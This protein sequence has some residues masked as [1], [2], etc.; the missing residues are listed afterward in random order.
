MSAND[1]PVWARRLPRAPRVALLLAGGFHADHRPDAAVLDRLGSNMADVSALAEALRGPSLPEGDLAGTS[2][3]GDE[4]RAPLIVRVRGRLHRYDNIHQIGGHELAWRSH[5]HAWHALSCDLTTDDVIR[6]KAVALDL[7]PQPRLESSPLDDVVNRPSPRL[8]DG[9]AESL[10]LLGSS[11]DRVDPLALV[12]EGQARSASAWADAIVQALLEGEIERWATLAPWLPLLAEAGP[13]PFLTALLGQLIHDARGLW[14]HPSLRSGPGREPLLFALQILGWDSSLMPQVARCLLHL[15]AVDT[16]HNRALHPNPLSCLAHLLGFARP[17]TN[18]SPEQRLAILSEL[19]H[20]PEHRDAVRALLLHLWSEGP[21]RMHSSAARPRF[22]Q[23]HIP[24]DAP[25][26]PGESAYGQVQTY[27]ELLLM[28]AGHEA[29][30]W[31]DVVR[32]THVPDSL[33]CNVLER[34]L[35]LQGQMADPY[36]HICSALRSVKDWLARHGEPATRRPAFQR[37]SLLTDDAYVRWTPE[38]PVVRHAFLF[39]ERPTLADGIADYSTLGQ[40]VHVRQLAALQDFWQRE[41]RWE[42]LARLQALPAPP[43]EPDRKLVPVWLALALSETPFADPLE[44]RLRQGRSFAPFETLAP[45]FLALR[46][47]RRDLQET[48]ALLRHLLGSGREQDAQNLLREVTRIGG[49]EVQI[50]HLLDAPPLAPLRRTYWRDA[51]NVWMGERPPAEQERATECL[52]EAGNLTE[53]LWIAT[54]EKALSGPVLLRVFEALADAWGNSKAVDTWQDRG[55]QRHDVLAELVKHLAAARDVD[56]MRAVRAELLLFD[57]LSR[58]YLYEPVFLARAISASPAWLAE[59]L[60]DPVVDQNAD[61]TAESLAGHIFGILHQWHGYPGD[62][63]LRSEQAQ[64]LENWCLECLRLLPEKRDLALWI[65]G[66]LLVRPEPDTNDGLWPCRTAR[67][68]LDELLRDDRDRLRLL[69]S[70]VQA[71]RSARGVTSRAIG[72]GGEQERERAAQ[73]RQG[74]ER[75]PARLKWTRSLLEQLAADY[76]SDA[77]HHDEDAA[78]DRWKYTMATPSTTSKSEEHEQKSSPQPVSVFPLSRVKLESF[79]ALRD[80]DLRDLDPHLNVFVG[81]N[82]SGKTTVLDAIAAGLAAVQDE[83]F[84]SR[85]V[86]Q[87]VDPR[88]DRTWTWAAEGKATQADFLRLQY[89]GQPDPSQLEP[90]QGERVRPVEAL[91][92]NVY[93]SAAGGRGTRD[94]EREESALRSPLRPVRRALQRREAGPPPVPIFAYYDTKRAIPAEVM[95]QDATPLEDL[96]DGDWQLQRA[97]AYDGALDASASYKLLVS[98]LRSMQGAENEL[99]KERADFSA[100]LPELEAV[101]RAVEKTVRIN[102]SGGMRCWNP[103]TKSRQA[104]LLVDFDR[105]DGQPIETIE[106]AQ[107]SDGFRTHLALVMDL[108]RRMVHAN[109]PPGGDLNADG[110]G[111]NS[112]A[113]VLIDEVDLHLH[114]GWQRNVLDDLCAAFPNAQ[115]IVTTHS[116]QVLATVAR[117]HVRLLVNFQVVTDLFTEGR[118]TNGLLEEIFGISPRPRFI[119]QALEKLFELLDDEKFVEASEI[120]TSLEEKLGTNDEA[121]VRARWLLDLEQTA[122]GQ[123]AQPGEG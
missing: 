98:W 32:A 20:E 90:K 78:E 106:L 121:I 101:R 47:A 71:R 21:V 110:W 100:R 42:L 50:W 68:F 122:R 61:S 10:A 120:L 107:L 65:I 57:E 85:I 40:R 13:R 29:R 44:A 51:K 1:L 27:A 111:T 87:L 86:D 74:I 30:H 34:L 54:N 25:P 16:E 35:A 3:L 80:L 14:K 76:E 88:I 11:D 115:F 46:L 118:D 53:A 112:R 105:G 37:R 89:W 81:R 24:V 82:A 114:P 119:R 69:Q 8:M 77:R 26:P 33:A 52:L 23:L 109:P 31:A 75:I 64:T 108:A 79:R 5:R 9:L 97:A 92:W 116:P 96:P 15:L 19:A 102:E 83:I 58:A 60:S 70:M 73:L 48:D 22:L 99:Q 56:L 2:G 123:K 41:D 36:G 66:M 113:V 62:E 94:A 91:G 59:R 117:K 43:A 84:G 104:G 6:L 72:E 45:P 93:R 18:A 28:L 67:R 38:D 4:D 55:A 39:A 95:H 63:R 49:R 7:L 12:W 103:R 17:Q